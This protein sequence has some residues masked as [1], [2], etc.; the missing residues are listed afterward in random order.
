MWHCG[1]F[2]STQL[3]KDVELAFLTSLKACTDSTCRLVCLRALLNAGLPATLPT[4]LEYVETSPDPDVSEAAIKAL[5]RINTQGNTQVRQ[6]ITSNIVTYFL[7]C[8]LVGCKLF[9]RHLFLLIFDL[10]FHKL[11]FG[12]R[13]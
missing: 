1:C 3:L 2:L 7:T 11:I 6:F 4:I 12:A 10:T 8:S 13:L 5:R 9:C